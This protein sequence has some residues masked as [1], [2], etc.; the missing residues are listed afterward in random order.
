MANPIGG[1]RVAVTDFRRVGEITTAPYNFS[2]NNPDWLLCDC[3]IINK[4]EYSELAAQYPA[5]IGVFTATNRTPSAGAPFSNACASNG[6]MW[7]IAGPSGTSTMYKTTDGITY[8]SIPTSSA[9]DI[10]S[11]LYL[12]TGHWVA[13]G[14]GGNLYSSN[15]GVSW[16]VNATAA[17]SV[18]WQDMMCYSS[19]LGTGSGRIVYVAGTTTVYTSDDFGVSWTP[20]VTTGLNSLFHICWTGSRFIA[21]INGVA[22]AVAVS[23]DG[24]TWASLSIPFPMA[25]ASAVTSF[26]ASDGKGNVVISMNSSVA[27]SYGILIS[28]DHG[29]TWKERV[30]PGYT[31][32]GTFGNIYP[33]FP[34]YTNDIFFLVA[35]PGSGSNSIIVSTNL[36]AFVTISNIYA[37]NYYDNVVYNSGTGTYYCAAAVVLNRTMVSDNS[38]MQLPGQILSTNAS[39]TVTPTSHVQWIKA[40]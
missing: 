19:T 28:N 3:S 16:G 37:L 24:V 35:S 6:T 40:R 32:Y 25:V 15:D 8:T 5:N 21:T 38:K 29:I 14:T 7:I 20:R 12:G 39:S 2:Y 22:N 17:T 1:K 30:I 27:S 10:G 23:N 11:I 18:G 9:G 34:S 13:V 33:G 4:G 26:I 31:G 36:K